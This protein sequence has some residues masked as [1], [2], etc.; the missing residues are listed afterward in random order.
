MAVLRAILVALLIPSAIQAATA[1]V[2]KPDETSAIR[3]YL[4]STVRYPGLTFRAAEVDLHGGSRPDVIVYITSRDFCGSGGCNTLVLERTRRGFRTVMNTTITRSP[5][6]VLETRTHEWR[7]LGVMVAG[8]GILRPYE[9]R[10]R[11][12]GRR[13]PPNPT[14]PP[15]EPLAQISGE[16]VIPE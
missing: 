2:V 12:N 3:R 16:I 14:V 10:L 6:R 13:Y 8:G 1:P 7:D 15:A 9:A 5:I 4:I 11:F